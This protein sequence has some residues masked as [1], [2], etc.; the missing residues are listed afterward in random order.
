[1]PSRSTALMGTPA[2]SQ[3]AFL[4]TL[5]T[6]APNH[7]PARFNASTWNWR[8]YKRCMPLPDLLVEVCACTAT[9]F[10]L[11]ACSSWGA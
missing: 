7:L 5:S 6:L 9:K 3:A 11:P 1:M 4:P 10:A 2:M 8:L